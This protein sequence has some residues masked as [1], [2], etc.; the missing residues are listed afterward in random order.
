MLHSFFSSL[1]LDFFYLFN[2]LIKKKRKRI[3]WFER[4]TLRRGVSH[5]VSLGC[6]FCVLVYIF[7]SAW[8][9]LLSAGAGN[10]RTIHLDGVLPVVAGRC[11]TALFISFTSCYS[12][13]PVC[14]VWAEVSVQLCADEDKA[15]AHG[16]LCFNH[17]VTAPSAEGR[18][19]KNIGNH[20][21]PADIFV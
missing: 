19:L 11:W 4:H 13:K 2:F 14:R 9:M 17:T 12:P 5:S 21:R 20:S 18:L 15:F 7:R 10:N 3:L 1:G 6:S 8:L 16:V